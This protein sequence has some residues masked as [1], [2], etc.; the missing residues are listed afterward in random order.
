MLSKLTSVFSRKSKK[1]GVRQPLLNK[2][3]KSKTAKKKKVKSSKKMKKVRSAKKSSSSFLMVNM[4]I[5]MKNGPNNFSKQMMNKGG[6]EYTYSK[7]G[8]K[9]TQL[10]KASNLPP[11]L[12]LAK[13]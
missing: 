1:T 9:Q 11:T 10:Y 5:E 8:R 6:L 3:R 4:P 2:K 12:N 7:N 13:K